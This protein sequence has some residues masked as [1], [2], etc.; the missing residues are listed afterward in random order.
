MDHVKI[1]FLEAQQGGPPILS[2]HSQHVP[3]KDDII[4]LPGEY[5]SWRVAKRH[6]YVTDNAR[7]DV[8][9]QIRQVDIHLVP[10]L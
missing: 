10:T 8:E 7:R 3:K 1:N 2:I 5:A 6:W 9:L 4:T